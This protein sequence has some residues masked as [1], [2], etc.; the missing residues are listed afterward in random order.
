MSLSPLKTNILPKPP[1]LRKL[2]GPSFVI[3][4]LGL[5]SGELILW[6]YMASKYGMGIIW[7]AVIGITFQFFM[8]MEIERYALARGE[9]VFMGFARKLK[10]LPFWFLISTFIPWIWPGIIASSAKLLGSLFGLESTQFLAIGLLV[11]I[12]LILSLGPVLYK[13][14]EGIQK[15]IIGLGVPAILVLA[16]YLASSADWLAAVKGVI[17][18]GDGYWLLPVGVPLA[19]FLGALA[20]AGAGGNL[21][22]AQSYYVNNKGYGMGKYSGQITSLLTGKS[23]EISLSG[24][25]FEP[26]LENVLTFKD[27]W[28]KVNI[29]HFI[30]FWL[31]GAITMVLLSLLA[32]STVYETSGSAS[33]INFVLTEGAL[34]GQKIFPIIG[35]IFVLTAAVMLMATQ[36]TVFDATSRILSENLILASNGRIAEKSIPKIYYSM[37]WVQIFAGILIFLLGFTQP[38][39]LVITAAVLNAFAM[40]VHVGLTLWMNLTALDKQLRPNIFRI[41]MMLSAFIFYGG[42]CAYVIFDTIL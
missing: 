15:V 23:Q 34:I 40:F 26:T 42:F 11:F 24:T 3:L 33:D 2:I 37:L 6:P 30:I 18:Q 39:Q 7:G 35:T 20:Y 12:G 31:T 17:G 21:N 9:S 28:K 32:Y 22:L 38:L 8:N 13:T 29:E 41:T 27:W 1:T 25:K 14:V 16:I 36:M 5:G 4:G 10:W 19:T